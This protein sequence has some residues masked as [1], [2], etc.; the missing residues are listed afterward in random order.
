MV[1]GKG[2]F[3][4]ELRLSSLMKRF[5]PVISDDI[6]SLK[7]LLEAR[8]ALE[9]GAMGL[10]MEAITDDVIPELE[11]RIEKFQDVKTY[12]QLNHVV[13]EFHKTLVDVTGN[14]VLREL[15]SI[16]KA[17]FDLAFKKEVAEHGATLP[18]G[19]ASG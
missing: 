14:R 11:E 13:F 4:A 3:V 5:Y 18:P 17:F 15:S 7:D 8:L 1:G 6:G 12:E 2:T 19:Y 10:V 16:L 9:V